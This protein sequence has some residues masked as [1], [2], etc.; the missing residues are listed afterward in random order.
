M[1]EAPDSSPGQCRFESCDAHSCCLLTQLFGC[2]VKHLRHGSFGRYLRCKAAWGPFWRISSPCSS[3]SCAAAD[4][5][6]LEVIPDG[7]SVRRCGCEPEAGYPRLSLVLKWYWTKGEGLAKWAKSPH[8]YTA[9]KRH[10][11]KYIPASYLDRVV[12]QWFKDV[13]GIWPGERKGAN[14][15]GPG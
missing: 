15:T 11:A 8:P 5:H 1:A 12:A 6:S 9:L 7:Q 14:P 13:F 3:A 2:G 10:L 4:P